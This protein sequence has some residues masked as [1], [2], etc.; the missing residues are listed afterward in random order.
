MIIDT[1]DNFERYVSLNPLFRDVITFIRSNDIRQMSLGKHLIQGD[2]PH[3][4]SQHKLS[5]EKQKQWLCLS[6]IVG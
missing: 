5:M 6:L 3:N 1:L 2:W 4:Y